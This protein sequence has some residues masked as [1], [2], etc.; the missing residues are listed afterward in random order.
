LWKKGVITNIGSG[1]KMDCFKTIRALSQ[2]DQG[3]CG[4]T[5]QD[6]SFQKDIVA[7]PFRKHLTNSLLIGGSP[8]AENAML[9]FQVFLRRILSGMSIPTV[10][11]EAITEL[12]DTFDITDRMVTDFDQNMLILGPRL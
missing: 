12:S 7:I 1:S 5:V 3:L 6:N 11:M 2:S 4:G 8:D 9:W 10:N